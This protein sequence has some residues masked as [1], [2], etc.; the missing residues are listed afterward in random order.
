MKNKFNQCCCEEPAPQNCRICS[1]G[2]AENPCS[3]DFVGDFERVETKH[4]DADQ[5]GFT[6]RGKITGSFILLA[7]ENAFTVAFDFLDD[8]TFYAIRIR[9]GFANNYLRIEL[10]SGDGPLSEQVLESQEILIGV[11]NALTVVHTFCL[12]FDA[13]SLQVTV[14]ATN[15]GGATILWTIAGPAHNTGYVA[16]HNGGSI[17]R[18]ETYFR[19]PTEQV[20]GQPCPECPELAPPLPCTCCPEG[21]AALW[22][23]DM[24]GFQ[25]TDSAGT[26]NCSVIGGKTYLLDRS[27]SQS[28]VAGYSSVSPGV[29]HCFGLYRLRLDLSLSVTFQRVEGVNQC[30]MRLQITLQPIGNIPAGSPCS[31]PDRYFYRKILPNGIGGL[32]EGNHTLQHYVEPAFPELGVTCTPTLIPS[33]LQVT[34]L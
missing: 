14:E 27:S 11:P 6:R 10:V 15:D 18:I 7:Q 19:H 32:C 13:D 16:Y 17:G 25:F 30:T 8:Q 23:V 3:T 34:S 24:T 20:E 21:I 4:P 9:R 1:V 29:I 28:C 26:V 5:A 12:E 33:T 31:F 22:A 2:V